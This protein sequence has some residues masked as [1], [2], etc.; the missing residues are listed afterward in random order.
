MTLINVVTIYQHQ[1]LAVVITFAV[2]INSEVGAEF[3][4]YFS[5]I[6]GSLVFI[7]DTCLTVHRKNLCRVMLTTKL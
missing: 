3:I 6:A 5:R 4:C 1:V 7:R 2:R